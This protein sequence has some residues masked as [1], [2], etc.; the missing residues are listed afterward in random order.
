MTCTRHRCCR[1]GIIG[2]RA[3][4]RSQLKDGQTL[5]IV[6][7]GSSAHVVVQI[8]TASGCSVYVVSRSKSHQETR[9]VAG[10]C[11]VART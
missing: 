10:G 1:A 8:A 7:M 11:W 3:L 4:I 2:Y 6:G 9:A 5:A